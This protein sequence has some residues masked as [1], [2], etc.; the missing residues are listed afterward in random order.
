MT[1]A[2]ASAVLI[3]GLL[4]G[5][6]SVAGQTLKE[7]NDALF[8]KLGDVCRVSTKPVLQGFAIVLS[9]T[10]WPHAAFDTALRTGK[11]VG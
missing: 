5:A 3:A 11:A 8:R 1:R 2:L 7:Q 10:W 9:A 4:L 6:V